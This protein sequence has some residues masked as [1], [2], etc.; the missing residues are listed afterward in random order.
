MYTMTFLLQHSPLINFDQRWHRST[1]NLRFALL[2][3]R[4]GGEKFPSK[5]LTTQL[6]VV[7][8]MGVLKRMLETILVCWQECKELFF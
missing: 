8:I 1:Q 7:P 3:E 5:A 6:K 4:I 2:D